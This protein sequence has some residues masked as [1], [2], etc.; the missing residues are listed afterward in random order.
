[1]NV[2]EIVSLKEATVPAGAVEALGYPP[3]MYRVT[4]PAEMNRI[5]DVV[6]GQ[7]AAEARYRNEVERW[8]NSS[9][10]RRREERERNREQQRRQKEREREDK[11]RAK[12]QA[13]TPEKRQQL[14]D[15]WKRRLRRGRFVAFAAGTLGLA[16]T[17]YDEAIDQSVDAY[18]SYANDQI[19]Y[20]TYLGIQK[21]I[22]ETFA[23]TLVLPQLITLVRAAVM[24]GSAAARRFMTG[25]RAA[26][27][28]SSVAMSTTGPIG[29]ALGVVKYL[30]VEAFMWAAIYLI[31]SSEKVQQTL[32]K[33]MVTGILGDIGEKSAEILA[34]EA[35]FLEEIANDV[36]NLDIQLLR[37]AESDVQNVM[38]M[39]QK[40]IQARY[41]QELEI[42]SDLPGDAPGSNG[43]D[44]NAIRARPSN[45]NGAGSTDNYNPETPWIRPGMNQN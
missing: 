8:N 5:P 7:D 43:F 24:A 29:I 4:Y 45:G 35:G 33:W 28:S 19:N 17:V 9:A 14:K 41:Q 36:M 3:G 34:T 16:W 22:W 11:R 30:L 23:F 38:G 44:P 26:N 42:G 21:N 1:M 12:A 27:L 6:T 13:N 10:D 20:E 25:I 15:Q 37:D 18:G 31:T 32:A 39:S 2:F 40:E